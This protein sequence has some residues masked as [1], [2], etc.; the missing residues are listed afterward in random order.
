MSILKDVEVILKSTD[1]RNQYVNLMTH[2]ISNS[3]E[4]FQIIFLSLNSDSEGL[5]SN[6]D[7]DTGNKMFNNYMDKC[8]PWSFGKNKNVC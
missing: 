8:T 2:I 1:Y 6:S 7:C 4:Q 5:Y 3:Q